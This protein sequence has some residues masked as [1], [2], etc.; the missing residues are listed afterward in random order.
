MVMQTLRLEFEL[1]GNQ[2]DGYLRFGTGAGI[3]WGSNAPSEWEE[4]EL[5]ANRLI[6]IASGKTV[7]SAVKF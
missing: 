5:K 6:A 4:T 2:R 7:E 3:T 1:S